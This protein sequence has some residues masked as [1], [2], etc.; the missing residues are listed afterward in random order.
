MLLKPLLSAAISHALQ[1]Y[2]SL[3]ANA[4]HLLAPLAGKV[5]AIT[6]TPFAQTLYFCP[7]ASDIQC[8]DTYPYPPDT[9]L[10]G[11]LV[12]F[13]MMSLSA[14]PMRSVFAGQVRIEGDIHTGRNFQA[15]FAQLNLNVEQL[16]A[17]YTG[18]QLAQPLA[19]GLR[20]SYTWQQETLNTLQ[21]NISEFL[22][23]ESRDLP[24]TAE[25]ELFFQHVDETR[26]DFDRLTQ[27]LQRLEVA[28]RTSLTQ[29]IS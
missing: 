6:V 10:T 20:A 3:D 26:L 18:E 12:A 21:L 27:R 22:Q 4:P 11:S 16:I 13:G 14:K 19:Q 8:L 1:H 25:A 28:A 29:V 17:R 2:L 7:S 15:L 24:A 23:D 5:I 9:H